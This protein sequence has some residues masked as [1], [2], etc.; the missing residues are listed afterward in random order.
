MGEDE[1]SATSVA[2]A[3]TMERNSGSQIALAL[4]VFALVLASNSIINESW[5]TESNESNG[6]SIESD[7]GLRELSAEVCVG[8]ICES[9]SESLGEIY[10]SCIDSQKGA[11]SS[12]K[13]DAC[14]DYADMHNAGYV[15]TI[16][17]TLS[18]IILFA[19]TIMQVRSM[20]G[21]SSRLPNF[22]SGGGGVFIALSIL[23]WS[24]MLPES[25]TDPEWGQGLWLAIMA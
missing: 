9:D 23:V 22:V 13:E 12:E 16:M 8:G 24:L 14:G 10:D 17:L 11:N 25:E 5:L 21:H 15:A 6:Q 20:M 4:T 19:A 7:L 18:G 3:V 1:A 2:A